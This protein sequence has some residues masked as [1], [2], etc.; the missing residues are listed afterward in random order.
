MVKSK[1]IFVGNCQANPISQTISQSSDFTR[2]FDVECF[3]AVHVMT[4]EDVE[5]LHLAIPQAS[6]TFLQ[7]VADGYR[8][9]I[10]LS[11]SE[12]S[13]LVPSNGTLITCPSIYFSGYNPEL[14]YLK[15]ENGTSLTQDFDYHHKVIF[16]A[17]SRRKSPEQAL[18]ALK[19]RFTFT[20]E[21]KL[22]QQSINELASRETINSVKI[23]PYIDEHWTTSRLF[24][25]FNH[26]TQ[27]VIDNVVDQV[28]EILGL[29]KS[30]PPLEGDLLDGTY[31]PILPGV[32]RGLGLKFTE[33]QK[34]RI[35][36]R[37][38][39]F[40][41]VIEKYYRLYDAHPDLVAT[42][43]EN[44]I[45]RAT[46]LGLVVKRLPASINHRIRRQST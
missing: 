4:P 16:D 20:S 24:W 41:S 10:G 27:E 37:E 32:R 28:L 9:N 11:T 5:R 42:N 3:P 26:P 15:T 25:T 43:S 45:S 6:V 40:K 39:G 46:Q 14:F 8:D 36:K 30:R 38:Y 35:R 22:A 23:S 18:S 33:K 31:Y 12:L 19:S 29:P 1:A 2:L 21:P 44:R 17:Y 13:S 7:Q 34:F